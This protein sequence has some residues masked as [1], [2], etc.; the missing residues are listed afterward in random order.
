MKIVYMLLTLCLVSLS[1]CADPT[2]ADAYV[3]GEPPNDVI[4]YCKTGTGPPRQDCDAGS[5]GVYDVDPITC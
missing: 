2:Q 1:G 5:P 4:F 3:C